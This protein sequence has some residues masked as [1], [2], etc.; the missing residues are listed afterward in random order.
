MQRKLN[1]CSRFTNRMQ[2]KITSRQVKEANAE[3][4]NC[5]FKTHKQNAGENH[6]K[7]GKT[8]TNFKCFG[9][10]QANENCNLG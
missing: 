10:T 4:T 2:E 5:M 6:I 3:K 9:T 8:V 1:I 7:V